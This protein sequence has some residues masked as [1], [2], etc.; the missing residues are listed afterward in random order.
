[1]GKKDWD[2]TDSQ[3]KD[4]IRENPGKSQARGHT[5]APGN[6]RGTIPILAKPPERGQN[7]VRTE[8]Y[9]GFKGVWP[10]RKLKKPCWVLEKEVPP[11]KVKPG[12]NPE[13]PS[14][15]QIRKR[16]LKGE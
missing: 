15:S 7:Q 16:G 13:L 12:N 1:M 3:R 14:G 10:Q 5:P 2:R 4:P 9:L 6:T 11:W 8:D